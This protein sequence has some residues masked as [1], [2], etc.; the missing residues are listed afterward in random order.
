MRNAAY[1][2][3]GLGRGGEVEVFETFAAAKAYYHQMGM[4]QDSEDMDILLTDDAGNI[5]GAWEFDGVIWWSS[6]R[7]NNMH[8]D[9]I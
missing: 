7:Y 2:T 4:R 3:K 8:I 1:W 6:Y 5:V 9:N